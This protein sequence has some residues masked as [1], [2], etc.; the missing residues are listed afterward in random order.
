MIKYKTDEFS[1]DVPN[2][3]ADISME[4]LHF[5]TENIEDQYAVAKRLTGLSI[6]Q[7]NLIDINQITSNL[8]F[9]QV[10][11]LDAV[12]EILDSVM[13]H[14]LVEHKEPKKP[15]VKIDIHCA[16]PVDYCAESWGQ[17]IVAFDALEKGNITRV[18]SCYV[19]PVYDND[20]FDVERLE[21]VEQLLS[22]LDV[23]TI[24]SAVKFLLDQFTARAVYEK[25]VIISTIT[26]EQ[27]K[28]GIKN[29]NVLGDF[30]TI[31]EIA[32]GDPLKY[33]AVL[34]LDYHTIFNKLLKNNI[35][36]RF[37]KAYHDIMKDK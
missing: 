10:P 23:E 16:L 15:K 12:E 34:R 13:L 26:H 31:D 9:F 25:K 4:T 11:P 33:E 2:S 17:K 30:N 1:F 14:K 35:T 28:A 27:I 7:L 5:I 19:Q 8:D 22:K 32:K 3:Y 20:K 29:F 24:Y 18:L 21:E 6:D 37:E 36:T